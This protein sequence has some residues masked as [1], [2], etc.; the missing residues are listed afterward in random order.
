MQDD[1]QE[2]PMLTSHF[3]KFT[4]PQ[5]LG[6]WGLLGPLLQVHPVQSKRQISVSCQLGRAWN[7]LRDGPL[8]TPVGDYR[9]CTY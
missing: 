8:G 7:P 4:R 3:L 9:D 5:D 6:F 1:C 2:K